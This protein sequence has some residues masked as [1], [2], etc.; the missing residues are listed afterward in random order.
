MACC[1]LQQLG[2]CPGMSTDAALELCIQ[3][4]QAAWQ[5]DDGVAS[6]L[7][8]DMAGVYDRVVPA[9]L[10]YNLRKRFLPTWIFDFILLFFLNVLPIRIFL[11]FLL[12]WFQLFLVPLKALIYLPFFSSSIMLTW[13]TFASPLT[14][15][16]L[17]LV[18]LMM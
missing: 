9:R 17:Q 3:Q 1:P 2:A 8:H 6:L 15:P 5:M 7:S 10:L 18:L 11:A 4:I 14:C 12:H 16:F 13:L